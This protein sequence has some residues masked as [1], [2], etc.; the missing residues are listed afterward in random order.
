MVCPGT[1]V[2]NM[3][4][5]ILPPLVWTL[6]LPIIWLVSVNAPFLVCFRSSAC[7]QR[8]TLEGWERI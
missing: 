4:Y 1:M 2:T 5:G 6:L 3:T 8:D 7:G